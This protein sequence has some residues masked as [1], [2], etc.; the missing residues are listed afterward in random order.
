MLMLQVFK[1][2][3]KMPKNEEVEVVVQEPIPGDWK[4]R[5]QSHKHE[6]V[7]AGTAEW[8]IKVPA[9]GKITLTYEVLIR[10]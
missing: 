2:I 5:N 10:Y 4:M 6:N 9:E 8:K 7:A 3:L 1:S